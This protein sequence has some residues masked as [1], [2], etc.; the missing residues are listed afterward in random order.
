MFKN[1]GESTLDEITLEK[2]FYVLHFQ[3]ESKDVEVFERDID[4]TFIQM[5]FCIR[6]NSKF[7]Q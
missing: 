7:R 5:H 3:N 1:V 2:G 6:G 4:S